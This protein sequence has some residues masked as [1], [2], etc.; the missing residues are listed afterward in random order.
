MINQQNLT[1]KK[2]TTKMKMTVP[3][4]VQIK[5]VQIRKKV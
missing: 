2:V 5:K 4:V 3:I 1:F